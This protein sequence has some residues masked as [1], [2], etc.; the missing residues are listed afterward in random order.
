[1]ADTGSIIIFFFLQI[2][3]KTIFDEMKQTHQSRQVRREIP[4]RKRLLQALFLR[5]SRNA[6]ASRGGMAHPPLWHICTGGAVCLLMQGG[7]QNFALLQI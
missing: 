5:A 6:F 7:G 2:G 4:K 1:M 3:A